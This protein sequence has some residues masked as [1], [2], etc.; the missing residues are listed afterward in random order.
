MKKS[1]RSFSAKMFAGGCEASPSLR[2]RRKRSY[3]VVVPASC[4]G[5]F[6]FAGDFWRVVKTVEAASFDD[7][8]RTYRDGA[9]SG[10]EALWYHFLVTD[11]APALDV[12]AAR[13]CP[14]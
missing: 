2:G 11:F 1:Q 9:G 7:A 10:G 12:L 4:P 3:A 13:R 6:Y 14:S 8:A 5:D